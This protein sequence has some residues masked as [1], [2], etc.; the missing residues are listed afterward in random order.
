V[1]PKKWGSGGGSSFRYLL[2]LLLGKKL[3]YL[4]S[5][6]SCIL[7]LST[8]HDGSYR[9][10]SAPGPSRLFKTRHPPADSMRSSAKMGGCKLWAWAYLAWPQAAQVPSTL[11]FR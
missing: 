7:C 10:P 3:A 4:L 6:E 8:A 11:L 9:H 1:G 5:V 2:D